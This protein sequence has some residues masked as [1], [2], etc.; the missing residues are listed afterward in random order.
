MTTT[1]VRNSIVG[2][3]WIQ[4]HAAQ[5]PIQRVIDPQTGQPTGDILTGP[6]RLAFETL[7]ELPQPTAQIQNPK[8]GAAL[9]FTPFADFSIL[10]EEY[11]K[12]CQRD[13]PEYY[14]AASGQYYG[15]HSP[16]RD[17]AEKVK[18]GGFTPGCVFITA[19]SKYKP[20]MIDARGNPI[21]DKSKVYP[22]VWA[23]C[24]INAYSFKDPRKKGVNFGL[25]NVMII[26]DD[27]KFGGGAA[28]PNKTFAGVK[29]AI[30]APNL[31]PGAL[32]HLASQPG[33]NAQQPGMQH[34]GA[35]HA[36]PPPPGGTY[37]APPPGAPGGGYNAV[38]GVG[39]PG[40]SQPL[41]GAGQPMMPPGAAP[42]GYTMPG[43]PVQNADPRGPAPA[44]FS[45]WA[46]Y[47]DLMG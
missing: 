32:A 13:F 35:G 24:S 45:T 25:Q 46:E 39:A 16:F 38:P 8:F 2:D 4:Q 41:P 30:A 15:L 33:A 11:Y 22:G 40:Y 37:A 31:P 9:L 44:G 43:A 3:A 28:D 23:I 5:I 17:Q 18:F 26:A 47:D 21:V 6:V 19:S 27:E 36:A 14:D 34:P 1:C 42:G 20:P 7:F 29:G 12:V 10:Y